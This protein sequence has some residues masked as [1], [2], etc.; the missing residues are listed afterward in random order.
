MP[1]KSANTRGGA[2]RNRPRPQ[3]KSVQLV[4]PV[5]AGSQSAVARDEE[6]TPSAVATTTAAEPVEKKAG[7][8]RRVSSTVSAPSSRVVDEPVTKTTE[9]T[10]TAEAI[11]V[12]GAAAAAAEVTAPRSASARMAARRKAAQNVQTRR[13]EN[14]ITAEHYAYVR[15]D[16]IFIAILAFLMLATLVVLHFVPGIGS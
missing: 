15:R 10:D 4:R 5:P 11:K 3:Q 13:S 1:K 12:T 16:L 14:L 7:S 6:E 2:S 9:E 8:R